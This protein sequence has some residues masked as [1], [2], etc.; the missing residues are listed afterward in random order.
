LSPHRKARE[1]IWE[2]ETY[3]RAGIVGVTYGLA[4]GD[5]ED[6]RR[7]SDGTLHAK[8]LVFGAVDEIT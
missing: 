8:L 2:L 1:E 3:K 5:F 7:E 4:S 6:L